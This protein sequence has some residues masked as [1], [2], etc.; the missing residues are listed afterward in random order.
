MP[1]IKKSKKAVSVLVYCSP[2]A[3][4]L[5]DQ[6]QPE[7]FISCNALGISDSVYKCSDKGKSFGNISMYEAD[8]ENAYNKLSTLLDS[9]LKPF[10]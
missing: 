10:N 1:Y 7:F 8:A 2:G 3:V 9:I 6:K 4:G 5:E